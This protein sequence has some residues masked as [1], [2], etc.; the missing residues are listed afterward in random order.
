MPNKEDIA[1]L[2]D[3]NN[4]AFLGD[5]G[6]KLSDTAYQ[7]ALA[8][9]VPGGG[10]PSLQVDDPEP[11]LFHYVFYCAGGHTPPNYVAEFTKSI[12][13]YGG[14]V[15]VYCCGVDGCFNLPSISARP[16]QHEAVGSVIC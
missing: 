4:F 5:T 12:V 3:K 8:M 6:Q 1:R 11:F 13:H 15:R 7:P 9:S 16:Q 10:L 2:A 14:K